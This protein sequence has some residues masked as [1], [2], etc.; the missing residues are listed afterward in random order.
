MWIIR[1]KKM[2]LYLSFVCM[3]SLFSGCAKTQH[4][5]NN[6]NGNKNDVLE[7]STTGSKEALY[8]V[9][10]V[11]KDENDKEK[12]QNELYNEAINYIKEN[13]YPQAIGILMKLGDYKDSKDLEKQ[14]RYIIEGTYISNGVW[15]IGAIKNDGGVQVVYEGYDANIYDKAKSWN[16][17]KI[18]EF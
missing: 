16:K 5:L 17:C 7:V 6:L 10:P 4:S 15:A 8:S 1:I 12:S 18:F 13:R 9:E 14:L 2:A 11:N 3:F